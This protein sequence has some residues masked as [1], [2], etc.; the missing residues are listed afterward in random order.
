MIFNR[1]AGGYVAS[2][3]PNNTYGATVKSYGLKFQPCKPCPRGLYSG[4]ASDSETDCLNYAG[5]GF[6]GFTAEACPAGSYVAANS[7]LDCQLCPVYRNTTANTSAPFFTDASLPATSTTL[8]DE[9]DAI[10]DCKVI[11]GYGV[12]TAPSGNATAD[13][14]LDV[15]PC[16]IGSFSLGGA[17]GTNCTTCTFP[18]TNNETASTVCDSKCA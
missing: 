5:F 8:G 1:T 16:E 10:E 18:T 4:P 7:R 17:V 13:V 9:Q 6:N 15:A 2:F 3:C 12:V 11:P 14:M